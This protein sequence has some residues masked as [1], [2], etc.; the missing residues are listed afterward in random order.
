MEESSWS[1]DDMKQTLALLKKALLSEREERKQ[2]KSELAKIST[3]VSATEQN[4]KDKV[5]A[6]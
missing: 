3:L 1:L 5:G 4:L 2:V 6:T